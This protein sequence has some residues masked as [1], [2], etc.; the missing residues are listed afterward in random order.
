M[1]RVNTFASMKIALS[2]RPV[3]SMTDDPLNGSFDSDGTSVS[4]TTLTDDE[5]N[6]DS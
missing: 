6:S 5:L 2:L 4:L 3:D 1:V